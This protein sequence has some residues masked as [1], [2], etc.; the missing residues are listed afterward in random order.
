[1]NRRRI[2]FIISAII[3]VLIIIVF[4]FWRTPTR[5]NWMETY[6][7]KSVQPYGTS[8]INSLLRSYY[9]EE[10]VVTIEQ[11]L[12][13]E[14]LL[15]SIEKANYVFIGQGLYMDSLDVQTLLSFVENGNTALIS[16]K[17]IPFDLMFYLYYYECENGYWNDYY[18]FTD[19]T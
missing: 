3:L 8:I 1:M 11:K 19:T 16:S 17:T 12:S 10:E 2:I 9:E 15:D 6:R 13:D 5:Y 4:L 14:L 7:S 18:T